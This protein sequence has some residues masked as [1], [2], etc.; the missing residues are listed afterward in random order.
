LNILRNKKELA[1][2]YRHGNGTINIE[3]KLAFIH[4]VSESLF[5]MQNMADVNT[6]ANIM[7]KNTSSM[8]QLF[9]NELP[10]KVM[11]AP[12]SD[13]MNINGLKRSS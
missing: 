1:K 3:I 11:T 10:Q 12:T 13:I 6:I 9:F 2:K 7:V 8:G 5:C 4:H